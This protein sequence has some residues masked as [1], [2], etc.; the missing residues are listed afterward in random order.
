MGTTISDEV[1]VSLCSFGEK[2]IERTLRRSDLANLTTAAELVDLMA[3]YQPICSS[4]RLAYHS[5]LLDL[6]DRH[7][8]FLDQGISNSINHSCGKYIGVD[9]EFVR[10]YEGL[11][12][13]LSLVCKNVTA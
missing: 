6:K 10:K 12:L 13:D 8:L 2:G 1:I 9:M 7:G 5:M 4:E 11:K 3:K